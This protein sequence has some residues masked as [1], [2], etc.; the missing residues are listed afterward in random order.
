V[1][2]KSK[3]PSYFLSESRQNTVKYAVEHLDFQGSAALNLRR[4]DRLR[5]NFLWFV[6]ECDSEKLLQESRAVA[7]R[8]RNAAKPAIIQLI[9]VDSERRTHFETK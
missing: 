3:S 6:S 4:V 5:R 7:G 9:A 2:Q 8:P 1:V